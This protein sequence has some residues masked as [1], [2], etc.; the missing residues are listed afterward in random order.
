MIQEKILKKIDILLLVLF[1]IIAVALSLLIN[2]SFF[3][4]TLLFFG[5]PSLW[6]SYRTPHMIKKVALF[7][8]II[9]IPLTFLIGYFAILDGSWFF[10]DSIYRFFGIITL[11]ELIWAFLHIYFVVIFYEHFFDKGKQ[12]LINTKMKY[13]VFPLYVLFAAFLVFY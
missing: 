1:P 10:P 9:C 13:L 2:A 11:E 3:V 12:E 5:L 7:S 8:L 6:L 4:S